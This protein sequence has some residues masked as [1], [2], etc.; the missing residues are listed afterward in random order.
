MDIAT[1]STPGSAGNQTIA[2]NTGTR[3]VDTVL[4]PDPGKPSGSITPAPVH[5]PLPAPPPGIP[6]ATP[7]YP[8]LP[9][10]GTSPYRDVLQALREM[11]DMVQSVM[12][13][14]HQG[15]PMPSSPGA[16]PTNPS[17]AYPAVPPDAGCGMHG[18]TA[19]PVEPRT[20]GPKRL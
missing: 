4:L 8:G 3:P 13:A 5:L 10:M 7:V 2:T 11:M 6:V 16:Y 19:V 17:Y 9:P 18:A 12:Q 15:G 20:T 14:V 1:T